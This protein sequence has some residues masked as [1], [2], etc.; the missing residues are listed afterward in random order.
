MYQQCHF[1]ELQIRIIKLQTNK[2]RRG[3]REEGISGICFVRRPIDSEI[4]SLLVSKNPR[5]RFL[6]S[7]ESLDLETN[8]WKTRIYFT[9]ETVCVSSRWLRMRASLV[10]HDV[11]T[12]W[13]G[14]GPPLG[15][16]T[17]FEKERHK[18]KPHLVQGLC[19]SRGGRPGLSVLT[20][21]LISVDV[22]LYWTMLR[23]WSQL[24]PNMSTAIRGH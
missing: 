5:S 9:P 11:I 23:H 8:V 17:Q 2:N 21:L 12:H 18:G 22:G 24:V 16:C 13:Q 15:L 19:E 10:E 3:K 7:Q 1:P 4:Q 14:I 20:S 6:P